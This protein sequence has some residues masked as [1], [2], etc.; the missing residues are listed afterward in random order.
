MKKNIAILGSTGSIGTQTLEVAK[1][2]NIKVN[3]ISGNKNIALLEKQAREFKPEIIA[4]FEEKNAKKLKE[5]IKDLN[6]KVVC[7][8]EGLCEISSMPQSEILVTA[9][10][11]MI[12]L[13]PTI[14]AINSKKDIALANKET[15]VAGG[16]LIMH[17]AKKNKVKILPVD[18]EHS[19][20]FQCLQG[21][22]SKSDLKRLIL[23]ASGG[24]FFVK[25]KK[26]LENVTLKEALNHPNW[27]MGAKITIDSATMMNKGLEI[28]EAVH[29]FGTPQ[30]K[31]DVIV[32]RESIVHSMIE[33]K[34]GSIIAQMGIPSMKTPIQYALTY[35]ERKPSQ[36]EN[37][38]LFKVKQLSFYKPDNNVFEAINICRNA[39]KQGGNKPII[40]NAANEEAV[41]LFLKN[42]IK[43][44]DITKIIKKCE[45]H[46][47]Y[48][49]INKLDEILDMDKK[50][51]QYVNF[52]TK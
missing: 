4:V 25:T 33:Y 28:I 14:A 32:H 31:I 23:T 9:I 7:G 42:K 49:K 44:T 24:P 46:F 10:S 52:I 39:I 17:L 5:N 21:M 16:N 35:P 11:G 6:S 38:D 13:Q 3:A 18:S 2:L 51:R 41:S 48:E 15:L 34:D 8:M 45:E 26:E 29:I 27:N 30:E 12:G 47:D 22:H 20:I 36:L 1:A 50:T 19:A 37:L 43:F 40:I